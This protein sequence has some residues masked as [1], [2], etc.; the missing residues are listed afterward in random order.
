MT[1]IR[2]RPDRDTYVHVDRRAT[3]G[4]P[5]TRMWVTA[6]LGRR[7]SAAVSTD[8]RVATIAFTLP[9]GTV[10]GDALRALVDGVFQL[11]AVRS[12]R[13]IE[14]AAP[15]GGTDLLEHVRRHLPGA[16]MRAAGV[17]CLIDANLTL[18]GG[19]P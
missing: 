10:P 1:Q 9:C 8:G 15:L 19:S 3:S 13:A 7:I 18:D 11:P 6:G 14:A 2:T 12:S 5:A 16:R 17:T 4:E